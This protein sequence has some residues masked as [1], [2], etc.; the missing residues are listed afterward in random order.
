MIISLAGLIMEVKL[1]WKYTYDLCKN[2]LYEGD[3]KPVFTV[4]ATNGQL[5]VE[6]KKTPGFSYDVL[7]STCV[8]R[9]I[10]EEI[11]RYDGILIHSAAISVDNEAYLFTANSGTGKTTHMNLWLENFGERAFIINGD[12]PILRKTD[13]GIFVYGTPWCGKEGYNKN[14]GIKLKGIC[15]LE[16][17]EKNEIRQ[18]DKKDAL[19]FLI[20][21]TSRPKNV[22]KMDLMLKNLGEI[23]K[24]VPVYRLGCNMEKEACKVAYEGMIN[25]KE[26]LQ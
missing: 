5:E 6:N 13:N 7:E 19:T 15:I 2:Y 26:E 12:K 23:I 10:C 9:N 3:E 4:F 18:T 17:A 21:Q 20:S 11:L 1:R 24:N 22:D 14:I 8:Y 16:R 25:K